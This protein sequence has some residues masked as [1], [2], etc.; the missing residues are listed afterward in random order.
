[1]PRIPLAFGVV[2]VLAACSR[3]PQVESPAPGE[4]PLAGYSAQRVAL[5]PTAIVRTDSLGWASTLGG[6]QSVARRTD[7]IL[8]AA[9][10]ERAIG[11]QWVLPAE[12]VRSYERNRSYAADPYHLAVE[13]L[14]STAFVAQSRYAEPLST[15][16]R[17]M[18]A[19]HD[20]LRYVLL[21]VEVR[22]ER[23]DGSGRAILR[24][25]LLDPRFAE[26]RWVGELK[27]DTASVPARALAQLGQRFADLFTAP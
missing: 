25:A 5:A 8:V 6:P 22:F 2:A 21:P 18:I 14:R 7:S 17:T 10:S 24:V 27:G 1:M 19:L 13:P 26:A 20:D 9:L 12:L 23:V 15:Q 11:S 4:R 16:L 3:A